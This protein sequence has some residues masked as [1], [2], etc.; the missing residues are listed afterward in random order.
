MLQQCIDLKKNH[1]AVLHT[2]MTTWLMCIYRLDSWVTHFVSRTWGVIVNSMRTLCWEQAEP[3]QVNHVK[4]LHD[5]FLM[6][7]IIL[8]IKLIHFNW[9]AIIIGF[10]SDEG[11]FL[12]RVQNEGKDLLFWHVRVCVGGGVNNEIMVTNL[13]LDGLVSQSCA[14]GV[15]ET[16]SWLFWITESLQ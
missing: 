6:C 3:E 9:I 15:T 10:Q 7:S 13:H 4:H 5:S 12:F 8:D 16:M 1:N 11:S 2:G 14:V